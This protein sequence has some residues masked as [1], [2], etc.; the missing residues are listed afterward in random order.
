M[1][2]IYVL[3]A[4]LSALI[5]GKTASAAPCEG[6]RSVRIAHT[7]IA[8]ATIVRAGAFVPYLASYADPIPSNAFVSLPEF[9]RVEGT[10]ART[11]DSH[12]EFEV[13]LP[14]N[15]WNGR[16]M[17]IG[18]GGSGGFIN[19]FAANVSLAWALRNGFAA[20]ST[21]TGHQAAN[22]DFS[23]AQGHREQR[24]DYHYRAIHDTAL[25]AKAII[26]AFY[27]SEAKHS[28]FSGGSD[29]GRQGLME[30]QRYPADYDGV[31]VGGPAVHR[32]DSIKAWIWVAQAVESGGEIPPS[33]LPTIHDA[34]VASC[35]ALDGLRDG[36]IS[37]P[38]K[39][40]FD[41]GSLLCTGADSARCLTKPQVATLT[42]FYA[43]PRNSKGE[44]VG[45]GFLPGAELDPAGVISCR[46]CKS[47]ALHRASIFLDG[48]FD[49]R[50][51][52]KTF[53]FDR[54]VQGLERSEDARLTNTT[55]PNLTAFKARGGKLMIVHGWSDGADPAMA[56]VRYYESVVRTMGSKSVEQF[57]RLYMVPGAYHNPS[58]GPGPTAFPDPMLKALEEWVENKIAPA[59][60]IAASYKTDGDATSGVARTRP[61]CPYPTMAIYRGSG[62]TN[63]A[64]SFACKASAQ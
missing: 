10:I 39:C 29:G 36:L 62:S 44:A 17:G 42:R 15:G 63:E 54:D 53:D 13:W 11:A 59:A 14:T 27:G 51:R 4:A 7:T 64:D 19:Y 41:P 30:A 38:T 56:S 33:K 24:I 40:R 8:A 57:F 60:V 21:D 5:V 50:F 45:V 49:G 26:R 25:A 12:A 18:N 43:G 46:D 61:L 28:Y 48:M 3:A 2:P 35:D 9:C 47:S 20:S 32:T 6:V 22:D 58:R 55:E 34:V 52:L 16:Y 23:F 1:R 37:E 31:L